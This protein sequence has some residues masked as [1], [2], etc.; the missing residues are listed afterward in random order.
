MRQ[1]SEGGWSARLACSLSLFS[2]ILL[3][4]SCSGDKPW[5]AK[6]SGGK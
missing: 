1:D 5:V 3:T 4:L 2:S 6:E